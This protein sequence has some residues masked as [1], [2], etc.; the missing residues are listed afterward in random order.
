LTQLRDPLRHQ[1]ERIKKRDPAVGDLAGEP[2]GRV[3]ERGE[4]DRHLDRGHVELQRARA[5]GDGQRHAL[6]LQERAD[7]ADDATH[8]RQRRLEGHVV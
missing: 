8:P 7:L 3:S 4:V 6:A 1:P 5:R 2:D